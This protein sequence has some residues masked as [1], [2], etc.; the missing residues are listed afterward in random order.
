MHALT[1]SSSLALALWALTTNARK[2]ASP[3][4]IDE[5]PPFYDWE[6]RTICKQ[7]LLNP[8]R[9]SLEEPLNFE[10]IVVGYAWDETNALQPDHKWN[11]NS[12]ANA[13]R[14][15]QDHL[16]YSGMIVSDGKNDDYNNENYKFQNGKPDDRGYTQFTVEVG[17]SVFVVSF[18]FSFCL[19]SYLRRGRQRC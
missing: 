16:N 5:P 11:W 13:N 15:I 3:P 17:S 10:V 9:Q 12:T 2:T 1:L 8:R 14:K 6:H 4:K 7:D 18:S 19:P